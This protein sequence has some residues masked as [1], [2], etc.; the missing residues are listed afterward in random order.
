[1]SVEPSVMMVW[2]PV[3]DEP[4]G[5]VRVTDEPSGWITISIF[6]LDGSMSVSD[7]KSVGP[8]SDGK[9]VGP[10]VSVEP[11]VVTA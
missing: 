3:I 11:S 2:L 6:E 1:M 9:S 8:V 7:G 10:T 5:R 4:G